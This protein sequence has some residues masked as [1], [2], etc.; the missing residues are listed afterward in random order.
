M[1]GFMRRSDVQSP[2]AALRGALERDGLPPGI[3]AATALGVVEMGGTYSG[4]KV[5]YIRVFD[6][7]GAAAR[8]VDVRS[9]ADLDA[10][11]DLVLRAGHVEKDGTVIITWRAPSADAATPVRERAD[12]AKHGDDEQFVFPGK[13]R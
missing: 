9:Y 4:R 10:H 13:D 6:P 12:R 8:G 7:A 2:S 5:T 11:P 3:D 1:F